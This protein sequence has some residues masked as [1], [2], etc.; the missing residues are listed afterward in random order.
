MG[1]D[2][3]RFDTAKIQDRTEDVLVPEFATFFD[4]G[5]APIWTVKALGGLEMAVAREAKEK[6]KNLQVLVEKLL[7][8]VAEDKVNA[9]LESLGI[10]K[11][12]ADSDAP[13]DYVW[14]IA[15]LHQGSVN[16]VI[17]ESQAVRVAVLNGNVF[18]K[19][20]NKILALS[21]AGNKLGE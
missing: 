12:S 9:L 13:D 6:S 15:C 17:D 16:P 5:E 8:S 19:L 2:V 3:T 20:T 21:G 18:Y 1:F 7:S 10:A 4:E 14:R 11:H